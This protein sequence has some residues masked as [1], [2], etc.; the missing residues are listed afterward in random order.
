MDGTLGFQAPVHPGRWGY[1]YLE[2][3]AVEQDGNGVIWI[4]ESDGSAAYVYPSV[5]DTQQP[6]LRLDGVAMIGDHNGEIYANMARGVFALT[7]MPRFQKRLVHAAIVAPSADT[8][9]D[10][11]VSGS[12]LP[13]QAIGPDGSLWASTVTQV[14][15]V[16]P[17]GTT[18]IIRLSRPYRGFYSAAP[19]SIR[20]TMAPDGS[21][22][23]TPRLIR[24]TK[25][26]RV[27]DVE[28]EAFKHRI[29]AWSV[30]FGRDGSAWALT[31]DEPDGNYV[32]H[33]A[34]L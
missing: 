16:H 29:R 33:F 23:A 3:P 10:L 25:D 7:T 2:G 12:A 14:V 22:W 27:E 11:P 9:S 17:D 13:V 34:P 6:R 19:L 4:S 1:G 8:R 20:L 32:V 5:T 31:R 21:I 26:D 15:H 18:K 28:V 24:I 30:A